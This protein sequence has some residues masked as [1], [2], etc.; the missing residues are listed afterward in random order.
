M[1]ERM[2]LIMEICKPCE[3]KET[4]KL[5]CEEFHIKLKEIEDDYNISF[6]LD[7]GK[8]TEEIDEYGNRKVTLNVGAYK[9]CYT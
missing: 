7:K 9:I 1:N 3:N 8:I 5:G 6:L 4:C 2:G